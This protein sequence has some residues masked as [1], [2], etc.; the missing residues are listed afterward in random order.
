VAIYDGTDHYQITVQLSS[1]ISFA[2]PIAVQ[3][4]DIR[5]IGIRR[6]RSREDQAIQAGTCAIVLDNR[7]GIYDPG[8]TSSPPSSTYVASTGR[9]MIARNYWIRVLCQLNPTSYPDKVIF[10]GKIESVDLDVQFDQTL[11]I[12]ATDSLAWMSTST[13]AGTSVLEL[14]HERVSRILTSYGWPTTISGK[15]YR[16]LDTSI[17]GMDTQSSKTHLEGI[18]ECVASEGGMFF[19]SKDAVATTYLFDNLYNSSYRYT[20]DDQQSADTVEYDTIDFSN[21]DLYVYNQVKL[22]YGADGSHQTTANA[23]ASGQQTQ[24]GTFTRTLNGC[25][26]YGSSST[27]NAAFV[28]SSVAYQNSIPKPRILKLGFTLVGLTPLMQSR[29]LTQDIGD[30]VTANRTLVDGRTFSQNLNIN[31]ISYD[32]TPNNWRCT[33]DTYPNK[34]SA[35]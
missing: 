14:G 15:N 5:S 32:I 29:V 17:Y 26:F 4:E 1:S 7:A 35:P 6:G 20:L 34:T 33:I 13:W 2:S 25:G 9:P 24:Y 28:A 16:N 10:T 8:T 21:G 19:I 18:D 27:Y 12:N 11:T 22:N 23:N 3:T 30:Q 31:Q